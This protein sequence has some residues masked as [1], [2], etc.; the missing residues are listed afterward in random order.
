MC[1]A[2]QFRY[3]KHTPCAFPYSQSS[4]YFLDFMKTISSRKNFFIELSHPLPSFLSLTPATDSYI[5]Y[6]T[7]HPLCILLQSLLS[8]LRPSP[9]S[10]EWDS[11]APVMLA[12]RLVCSYRSSIN[13]LLSSRQ[14]FKRSDD[15][16]RK[17]VS[18]S[19]R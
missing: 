14:L 10:G 5:I 12:G 11:L 6:L 18:V 4:G 3:L 15:R 2:W 13:H 19:G 1:L 7:I 9:M 16:P 8:K 17:N